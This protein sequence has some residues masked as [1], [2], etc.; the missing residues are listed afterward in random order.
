MAWVANSFPIAVS[1]E[2]LANQVWSPPSS[3]PS[4]QRLTTRSWTQ[5]PTDDLARDNH[6]F[7]PP[8]PSPCLAQSVGL[9]FV[10]RRAFNGDEFASR[11]TESAR[12]RGRQGEERQRRRARCRFS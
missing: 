4:A 7:P 6:S 5:A 3:C 11:H 10:D 1:C 9:R 12:R 2:P 8:P